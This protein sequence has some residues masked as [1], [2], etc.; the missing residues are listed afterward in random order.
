M[1]AYSLPMNALG[2]FIGGFGERVA[3]L[4]LALAALQ[5]PVYYAAYANVVAGAQAEAQARYEELTTEAARVGLTVEDFVRRHEGNGDEVFQASGRI[6]RTTLDHYRRYGVIQAA[7]EQAVAWR[8]P[9]VLAQNWERELAQAVRFQP[10]LPLTTEAAL[11]ALA[12]LLAGWM[13]G[14]LLTL[15]LRRRAVAA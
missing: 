3:G 8:K 10:G 2:R 5:F 1:S 15:P 14:A 12:G 6:H 9:L 4:L 7:L 13:L 11:Y